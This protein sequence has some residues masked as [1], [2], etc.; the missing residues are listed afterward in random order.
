MVLGVTRLLSARDYL[1]ALMVRTKAMRTLSQLFESVD[2][3]ALPTTA[4]TA[5]RVGAGA[6]RYGESNIKV[7]GRVA[8]FSFLANLCG[9]PAMSIPAGQD[10]E[11]LPIGFQL[12]GGHCKEH[13]V[14]RV[15][16]AL[17]SGGWAEQARPATFYDAVETLIK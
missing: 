15:A 5:P 12:M 7:G 9:L 2:V 4:T 10:A 6:E 1:A 14:L 13:I 3:I 17:D 8:R 11:G 16:K